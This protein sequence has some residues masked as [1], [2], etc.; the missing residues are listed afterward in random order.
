MI[1]RYKRQ[2]TTLLL[3]SLLLCVVLTVTTFGPFVSTNSKI[4]A[5]AEEDED[6]DD[7]E[8]PYRSV[9]AQHLEATEL[10]QL[11]SID[12]GFGDGS[13]SST[14][15]TPERMAAETMSVLTS[16][17]QQRL[18]DL[19]R[20]TKTPEC[21]AKIAQ[22]MGYHVQALALEEPLPFTTT[23]F[24]NT[25]VNDTSSTWDFDNLPPGVHMGIIQNR[26]YQP[27]RNNNESVVYLEP[28]EIR[29]VYG[30]LA[31]DDAEAT[32]RL[33]EALSHKEPTTQFLVHVDAKYDETHHRL[34]DYAV[35]H[36]HKHN[37]I[38]ILE[39]PF[40][41]RVNWGGFSMVNATLQLFHHA[42][43]LDNNFTHFV[44]VAA[45]AYPIASNRR[46]RLTLAQ[47]PADANFFHVILKPARPGFQVWNYFVECDD[48]LH[49]IS[50]LPPLRKETHGID[51]YTSS[52]WFIASRDYV[53]FV[54]HPEESEFLHDFIEYAQHMVVADETFFGTILRATPFCHKHHNRNYLHLLFDLWENE[55]DISK[56][57]ERKCVMPDPNH[58]GR[59]PT[60]IT[61]DYLDILE[62]TDDLFARKFQDD[63]D[64]KIKDIIDMQRA[65]EE[66]ELLD[67]KATVPPPRGETV[68][69]LMSGHGALIVAKE[70]VHSEQPLCLGLGE[71]QNKAKLVPC[72]HDWV[73]PTLASDWETGGVIVDETLDHNRWEIAPCSSDGNLER[74]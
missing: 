35:K 20:H 41:V 59:S 69:L 18:T 57:D 14:S 29:L 27:P 34:Q 70:T 15:T 71:R 31:H 33:I 67:N 12:F 72:F 55:R 51:Q 44:H 58:C 40:R 45:S 11:Q 42:D 49:R 30:I 6:D 53:H 8:E 50:Q 62:L 38:S 5:G 46:I 47:Y 56:R 7:E 19:F 73:P 17:L 1:V 65:R 13:S 23:L 22:H 48:R 63:V 4:L 10:E 16:D 61:L 60:T 66:Q 68:N 39:D 25:C 32:I 36:N 37:K 24:E 54:A 9:H 21:R 52:Q 26:T 2:T 28:E 74:L 43:Q 64:P 3:S